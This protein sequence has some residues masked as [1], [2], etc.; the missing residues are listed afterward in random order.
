RPDRTSSEP[1]EV[2]LLLKQ[3]ADTFRENDLWP[4]LISPSA[5]R[6]FFFSFPLVVIV[7]LVL[8]AYSVVDYLTNALPG[9]EPVLVIEPEVD[10]S[11]EPGNGR[12]S[13]GLLE[14][15]ERARLLGWCQTVIGMNRIRE[16]LGPEHVSEDARRRSRLCRVSRGVAR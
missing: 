4:C 9:G 10:A 11:V 5:R 16:T 14:R 12:L 6:P 3:R 7:D 15:V 1:A 13:R 8:E 2:H